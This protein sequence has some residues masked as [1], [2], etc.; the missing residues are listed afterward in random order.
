MVYV[1]DTSVVEE[2]IVSE[3]VQEGR[4]QE[5]LLP[6]LVLKELEAQAQTGQETG[7]SGLEELQLLQNYAQEGKITIT[8]IEE[9]KHRYLPEEIDSLIVDIAYNEGAILLTANTI[10]AQAAM[11]LGIQVEF[12]ELQ[13]KDEIEI[14]TFFDDH[15]MSV[16][17]KDGAIP[18]A[19]RGQPGNWEL[20]ELE[21]EVIQLERVQK[22]AKEIVLRDIA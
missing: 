10:Q 16:H 22:I 14:E 1:I 4:I 17:I 21:Q 12:I 13:A 7:L 2:R 8:I 5:I 18:V 11:A 19:K 9:K 6:K 15:T 20:V 3:L